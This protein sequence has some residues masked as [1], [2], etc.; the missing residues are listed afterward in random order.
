[1]TYLAAAYLVIWLASF[2][3]ILSMVRRQ[4]NLQREINALRELSQE[5]TN[6]TVTNPNPTVKIAK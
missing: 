2:V 6:V 4:S 1:M 5:R 3:F